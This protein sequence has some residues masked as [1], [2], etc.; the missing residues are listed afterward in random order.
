[1]TNLSFCEEGLNDAGQ[2]AFIAELADPDSFDPRTAVFRATPAQLPLE[3]S[4]PGESKDSSGRSLA[5]NE[6]CEHE[7]RVVPR[8]EVDAVWRD[9]PE[10]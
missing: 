6:A 8:H 3:T 5:R 4:S 9:C 2:L 7:R 1:M 10:P